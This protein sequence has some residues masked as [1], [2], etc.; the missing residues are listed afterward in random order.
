ME[1]RGND[2]EAL[3]EKTYAPAGDVP[4]GTAPTRMHCG[5]NGLVLIPEQHTAAISTRYAEENP[6]AVCYN[7]IGWL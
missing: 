4:C 5:D 3:A 1:R 7:S 6:L 2:T